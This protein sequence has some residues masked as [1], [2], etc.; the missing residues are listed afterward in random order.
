MLDDVETV[1]G[2]RGDSTLLEMQVKSQ[3]KLLL[4]SVVQLQTTKSSQIASGHS[5]VEKW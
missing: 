4:S 2:A 1:S 3:L 5:S